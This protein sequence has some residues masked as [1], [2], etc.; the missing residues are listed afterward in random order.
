MNMDDQKPGEAQAPKL[1]PISIIQ[2]GEKS[3]QV[4]LT[5][6]KLTCLT[7]AANSLMIW[8]LKRDEDETIDLSLHN[9]SAPSYMGFC[10]IINVANA[11]NM[12]K[13]KITVRVDHIFEDI[14]SYLILTADEIDVSDFGMVQFVPL[15]VTVGKAISPDKA[16]AQFAYYLV[17]RAVDRKWLTAQDANSIKSDRLVIK[18]AKTLRT[19]SS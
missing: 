15:G 2:T 12:C 11:L 14:S 8:L 13:A 6:D 1:N 5:T 4:S 16:A 3:Y 7:S 18:T 9:S 10:T 19:S 17:D